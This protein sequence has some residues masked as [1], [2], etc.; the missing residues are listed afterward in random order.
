VDQLIQEARHAAH[1]LARV[2]ARLSLSV[3]AYAKAA[4]KDPSNTAKKSADRLS[5]EL[6]KAGKDIERLLEDLK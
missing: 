2:S 3:L 5:K 4:A 6:E 1:D